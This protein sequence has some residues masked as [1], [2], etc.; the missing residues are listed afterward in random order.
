[1]SNLEAKE[2]KRFEDIRLFVLTKANI[3]QHGSLHPFWSTL[4]GKTLPR[5][6]N[7]P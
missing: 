2:Y 1:L 7:A 6:S 3:G 4:N 5:L